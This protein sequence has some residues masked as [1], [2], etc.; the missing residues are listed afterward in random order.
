M[1]E[2]NKNMSA[3]QL[4]TAMEEQLPAIEDLPPGASGIADATRD[5]VAAVVASDVDDGLRQELIEQIQSIT[6]QLRAKV[7]DPFISLTRHRHGWFENVTQAGSGWWN[8]QSLRI[9]FDY[10][11]LKMPEPDSPPHPV[12][13]TATCT[14]TE[15]HSG[16]PHRAHGGVVMTM[17][18]EILGVAS[19]AAGAKGMTAGLNIR[20][21]AGTPLGV[22]LELRA[23]YE[24]SEGRKNF[25]TGEVLADGVVTAQAEGVFI[26]PQ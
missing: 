1:S 4:A 10:S 3:M 9:Q 7:R 8:P 6:S 22:P 25:V 19:I 17:L 11:V 18:D 16:P 2:I 12:E 23:R 26:S 13:V 21:K 20:F 15:A 14:L 5:L 24:R